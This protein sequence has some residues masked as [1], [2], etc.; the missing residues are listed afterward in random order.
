MLVHPAEPEAEVFADG[1]QS[2]KKDS[3]SESK[4]RKKGEVKN[5]GD[6]SIISEEVKPPV[7]QWSSITADG[8]VFRQNPTNQEY[9]KVDQLRLILETNPK[10]NEVRFSS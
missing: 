8:Q 6:T 2:G 4:G 9:E 5:D 1:R 7:Y 10:T 3:K